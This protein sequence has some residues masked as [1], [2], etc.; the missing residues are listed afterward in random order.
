MEGLAVAWFAIRMYHPPM[1]VA[2][3]WA[4]GPRSQGTAFSVGMGVGGFSGLDHKGKRSA[5][6]E[7]GAAG[8]GIGESLELKDLPR[9]NTAEGSYSSSRPLRSL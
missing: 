1:S 7:S 5:D 6:V 2:G 9:Q 4:W 3:G 8:A